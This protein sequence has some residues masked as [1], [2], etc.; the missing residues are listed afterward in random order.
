MKKSIYSRILLK[1]S[2]EALAGARPYGTDPET[3]NVLA[4]EIK[5]VSSLGVEIALVLGGGNI[6][7]GLAASAKGM[8]RAN[9]DYIGMI[10]TVMNCLAFQDALEKQNIATRVMTAL[11]MKEVA[12]PYIRRRAIRHMEKGRVILLAGGTGNPYFTTDTAATLRALEIH[13]QVILKGTKV[14]GIYSSDPE[15]DA[16]ATFYS[17]ISHMEVLKNKLKVMDATAIS[18]CMDTRLPVHVFNVRQSGNILRVVQGESVGSL[19]TSQQE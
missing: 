14:D 19:V 13:A 16:S 18:L 1:L 10:A 17:K 12:E 6:F 4:G 2:G 9:A 8:D 7:R 15:T 11:E 3:L 5:D